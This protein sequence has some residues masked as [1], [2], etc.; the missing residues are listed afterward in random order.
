MPSTLQP[1]E[2]LNRFLPQAETELSDDIARIVVA[3]AHGRPTDRAVEQLAK[4]ATRMLGISDLHGRRRVLIRAEEASGSAPG[5]LARALPL[6]F[7]T[8]EKAI[9]DITRRRPEILTVRPGQTA[10]EAMGEIYRTGGFSIAKTA[11][12]R[13][14]EEVQ[15]TVADIARRGMTTVRGAQVISEMT[16]WPQTYSTLV[17][18]N[19]VNTAYTSGIFRQLADPAVERVIAGPMHSAVGDFDTTAICRAFNGTFAPHDHEIWNFRSTPCHHGCRSNMD[20]ITWP[21]ARRM[22]AVDRSGRVIVRIPNP[23]VN[24]A[25]GFGSRRIG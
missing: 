17:V 22:G 19:N 4:T 12:R 3:V 5:M 13:V 21:E 6:S 2:E 18:R 24:A 15:R 16:G 11:E 10:S 1:A 9:Q 7:V 23:Q 25:P 20:L 8:F 14:I